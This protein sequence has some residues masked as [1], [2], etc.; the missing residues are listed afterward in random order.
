MR[1]VESKFVKSAVKPVDYYPT[2]FAEIAF[3]GKSNVGK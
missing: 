1:I 2:A 3:A